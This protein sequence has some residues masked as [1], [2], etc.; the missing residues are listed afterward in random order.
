MPAKRALKVVPPDAKPT[1]KPLTVTKAADEGS[2]RQLLV[3]MRARLARSVED[4]A[5]PAPALAA[6]SRQLLMVDKEIRTID[7]DCGGDDVGNAADTPDE[8]W[9]TT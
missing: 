9:P 3:A 1:P 4:P 5:T 2:E 7:A 8:E 6:L